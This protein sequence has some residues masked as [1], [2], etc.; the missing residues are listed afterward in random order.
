MS[1]DII[2]VQ[3]FNIY[4]LGAEAVSYHLKD[5]H[6]LALQATRE[7][8]GILALELAVELLYDEHDNA[9]FKIRVERGTDENPEAARVLHVR[10]NDWIVI[11]WDEIHL[12]QDYEFR[13]TFSFDGLSAPA[14]KEMREYAE[15]DANA[16]EAIFKP[17]VSVPIGLAFG[18]KP[19]LI[20]TSMVGPGVSPVGEKT[21][22]IG[23]KGELDTEE[24]NGETP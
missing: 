1:G 5:I 21:E 10:P 12:Y 18:E 7:N 9:Y 11:L 13:N 8:I 24:S 22:I 14:E 23:I 4:S 20:E 16:V 17:N 19:Q 15:A 2:G 3:D 6:T